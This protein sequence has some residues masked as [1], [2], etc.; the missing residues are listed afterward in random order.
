MGIFESV[1]WAQ[2]QGASPNPAMQFIPLIIV[3]IIMYVLIIRPTLK[4]NKE[5]RNMLSNI[6]RGDEVWTN[7]GLYGIVEQVEAAT[8]KLK[9]AENTSVKLLKAQISAK[10]QKE[11]E[12]PAKNK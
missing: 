3:G 7:G 5:H 10:V 6:R 2:S 12:P 8:V 11:A 4:K 9:I 1:A